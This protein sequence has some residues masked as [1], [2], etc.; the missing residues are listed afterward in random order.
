MNSH[1]FDDIL[2]NIRNSHIRLFTRNCLESANEELEWIPASTS[3]KYH[4]E[5]CTK[6][7]GLIVH[8][9][10]ACYFGYTF[11]KSH[12]WEEN[13]KG[14]ILISSLLLHDI[15]KKGDYKNNYDAYINHPLIGAEQ[16]RKHAQDIPENIF[17]IIFNCIKYHYGPWTHKSYQKPMEQYTQLEYLTYL[18]DFLSSQKT[19]EIKIA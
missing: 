15:A 8:I 2:S 14:D 18:A 11:I 16:T 10:R 6:K 5:E 7:G 1:I 3:G 13:I 4:P 9:Q 19:L 12:Q 17:R